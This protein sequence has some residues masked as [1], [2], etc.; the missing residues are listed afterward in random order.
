[1]H[2]TQFGGCSC[3]SWRRDRKLTTSFEPSWPPRKSFPQ[4]RTT[5]FESWIGCGLVW[6]RTWRCKGECSRS[7]C[8]ALTSAPVRW[9]R[10]VVI[11]EGGG[12]GSKFWMVCWGE[13]YNLHE[14][15]LKT[16]KHTHQEGPRQGILIV[17]YILYPW[18]RLG[19]EVWWVAEEFFY[20]DQVWLP[21][22]SK[23]LRYKKMRSKTNWWFSIHYLRT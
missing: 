23:T 17:G 12:R 11:L 13:P 18:T 4:K 5:W 3:S 2:R 14:G 21:Y 20:Q 7:S 15:G 6:R 9:W 10:R 1:M 22:V 19:P 16:E 8:S